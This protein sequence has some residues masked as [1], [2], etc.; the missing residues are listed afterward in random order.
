MVQFFGPPGTTIT[1]T[2]TT[3]FAGQIF[4]QH[5]SAAIYNA[6]RQRQVELF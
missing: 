5:Y 4:T 2:T 6:H 3:T 1:A